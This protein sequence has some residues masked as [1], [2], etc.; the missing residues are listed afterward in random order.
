MGVGGPPS[1]EVEEQKY[2]AS[3]RTRSADA[4]GFV[5]LRERSLIVERVAC[6]PTDALR[7]TLETQELNLMEAAPRL[8]A[9]ES[10]CHVSSLQ[11]TQQAN[12][13]EQALRAKSETLEAQSTTLSWTQ[14]RC[15][16]YTSP[17][18]RD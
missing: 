5:W 3:R 10:A 7:G 6:V 9:E 2:G 15:L 4:S 16:L 12:E 13:A 11:F 18:P 8:Q 17:S 14:G 1:S